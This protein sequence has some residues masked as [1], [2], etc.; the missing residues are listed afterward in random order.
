MTYQQT[1]FTPF[2]I[3]VILLD[4]TAVIWLWVRYRNRWNGRMSAIL[5]LEIALWMFGNLLLISIPDV[6]WQ[7][8]ALKIVYT[9]VVFVPAT[10]L[11][12]T[13]SFISLEDDWS[14]TTY[15]FF[16][17]SSIFFLVM[18]WT[19]DVHNLF[20]HSPR[21]ESFD[22][23]L[24]L[25][26]ERGPLFWVFI[27]YA[28]ACVFY[29]LYLLGRY[30][31]KT[32]SFYNW[33][34]TS[35]MAAMFFP[36][37]LAFADAMY[38]KKPI[39]L[40]PIFLGTF[41]LG[42]FALSLSTRGRR[43]APIVYNR[44]LEYM[45]D[46]LIVLDAQHRIRELS[47]SAEK[48]LQGD[49]ST[50][51]GLPLPSVWTVE[52]RYLERLLADEE[53]SFEIQLPIDGHVCTFHVQ[54]GLI[55]APEGNLFARLILFRDM[56]EHHQILERLR[57]SEERYVL[58]ARGA[59]AGLFDWD[60]RTN[61]IFYAPRWKTMLGYTESEISDSP[62]EWFWRV[63]PDD[64]PALKTAIT[65]HL[66]GKTDYMESEYRIRHKSGSYLWMWCRAQALR[67]PE[68][69]AYRLAGSQTDI[70]ERKRIEE[71]LR[72]EAE[73]DPLTRLPNRT[74]FMQRL[75]EE[76]ERAQQNPMYSYAVVF[77]DL[78]RFKLINDTMGHTFGDELLKLVAQRLQHY[79]QWDMMLARFGGDE[80]V[81]LITG[82]DAI[83]RAMHLG[84]VLV[85]AFQQPFTYQGHTF[86]FTLSMGI[87]PATLSAPE[88][89]LRNADLALYR[90]K[91]QGG[92]RFAVFDETLFRNAT[93]RLQLENALR[94][95]L[96]HQ[97]LEIY[98]QPI[99]RLSTGRLVGFEVLVRWHHPEYGFI[100][101]SRFIP[102]AEEMGLVSE[103]DH[104][105]LSS[106][107]AT[108]ARWH[109]LY[110]SS[111]PI[112][113]A[114]N[115]SGQEFQTPGFA[116]SIRN[117]L[118]T[119]GVR[120]EDLHIEITERVLLQRTQEAIE[121]IT[122]L[123]RLGVPFYIDDFGTGYSSLSYLHRFNISGLKIDR[124][125][126][127]NTPHSPSTQTLVRAIVAMA[128]ALEIAVVVEGVETVE[129]MTLLRAM[130]CEYGQGYF[131]G[132]PLKE[133][134]AEEWLAQGRHTFPIDES[135]ASNAG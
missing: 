96:A 4:L 8:L 133:Q 54:T 124:S 132:R 70:T 79:I 82:S 15:L 119:H 28:F 59:S 53:V 30:F 44:I 111:P 58:A 113:I 94:E 110:P 108:L 74:K 10:W 52:T 25:I 37:L 115:F 117:L 50:L 78:D 31:Y 112:W 34:I 14:P 38:I 129:Q 67:T 39:D 107:L 109:H 72:F 68:G 24:I 122:A 121:E 48:L 17:G 18:A 26:I 76:F 85:R 69:Q 62:N 11:L 63:H 60:L 51:L 83:Q 64:R 89:V 131:F 36:A 86:H 118:R 81:V 29:S 56:T 128:H 42:L 99:V 130:G 87:A 12:W 66:A 73:H 47:K 91:E 9:A 105:V 103:I 102:I 92:G 40:S 5:L 21:L 127:Q 7:L 98:F 35:L 134:E 27:V 90:A 97:D 71:A 2:L 75:R 126:V 116:R 13:Y 3:A 41:T 120:P 33:Q 22:T 32:R 100:P 114:V 65:E 104:Y 125:F 57:E 19:N 49:R 61:T 106:A 135:T 43:L 46:A 55:Y 123:E 80:F 45:P 6:Q 101:P 84:S 23:Y 1:P 95:A 16:F 77:I 93:M 88:D 20:W